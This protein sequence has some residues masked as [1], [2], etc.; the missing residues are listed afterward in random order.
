MTSEPPAVVRQEHGPDENL[1]DA[2]VTATAAATGQPPGELPLL[3]ETVDPEGLN[4]LFDSA[5]ESSLRVGFEYA[6]CHIVIEHEEVRVEPQNDRERLE[7][8]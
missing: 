1:T 3:F 8:E 7:F 5:D 4:R 2:I 6:G